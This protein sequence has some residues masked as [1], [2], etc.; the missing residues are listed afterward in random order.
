LPS[1]AGCTRVRVS[2]EEGV[3][4][5]STLT[6]D[7]ER[8][9]LL[10]DNIV[11]PSAGHSIRLEIDGAPYAYTVAGRTTYDHQL[12]AVLHALRAGTPLP[13]EGADS[14]ANMR[15]IDAIYAAAGFERPWA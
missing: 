7:A 13:T 14:V 10:V 2:M 6:I 9:T 8:G 15:V 12:E 4:L 1:L 3:P 11:F 5:R